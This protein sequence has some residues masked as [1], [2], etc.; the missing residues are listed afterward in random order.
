MKEK[1]VKKKNDNDKTSSTKFSLLKN[2][3]LLRTTNDDEILPQ[4][5]TNIMVSLK[6]DKKNAKKKA[7]KN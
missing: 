6:P 3:V 5:E 2:I 7:E 4:V 1:L